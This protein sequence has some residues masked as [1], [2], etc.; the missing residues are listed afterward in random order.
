VQTADVNVRNNQFAYRNGAGTLLTVVDAQRQA[1]RARLA[2][3]D[4]QISLYQNI[5]LLYVASAADWRSQTQ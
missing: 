5:A 2:A 4:A 3:V 1:N